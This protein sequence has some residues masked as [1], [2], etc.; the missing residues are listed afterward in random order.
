MVLCSRRRRV[1][2]ACTGE[3][4][5]LGCASGSCEHAGEDDGEVAVGSLG[6]EREKE[7]VGSNRH[8][9]CG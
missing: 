6:S 3:L 2:R 4:E 1:S 9:L 5:L 8:S 7:E